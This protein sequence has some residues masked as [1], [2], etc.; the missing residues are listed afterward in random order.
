MYAVL[1]EKVV[2]SPA[3]KCWESL[4]F[5]LLFLAGSANAQVS[6]ASINGVIRDP[7]GACLAA[8]S[9][10]STNVDNPRSRVHQPPT[11]RVRMAL[12]TLPPGAIPSSPPLKYSARKVGGRCVAVGQAAT[13]DFALTVGTETTVVTVK[14]TAAQLDERRPGHRDRDR[15]GQRPPL[16]GRVHFPA[17][18]H[19]GRRC[20]I[21]RPKDPISLVAG[22]V[23][24]LRSV[25][26]IPF[27]SNGQ[28]TPTI[29]FSRMASQ[30]Y[31]YYS[32][33]AVAL[34]IDAVQE[35]KV[36]SHTD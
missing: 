26:P 21:D 4:V 16:N 3:C 17:R 5:Q 14:A 7:T 2:R 20:D 15:S 34:I 13:F 28:R 30:L 19:S 33:Y 32:T 18:A 9:I 6:T 29:T 8:L 24:P 11:T 36:V 1:S 22:S 10:A 27:L 12:L 23:P 31:C 35:F 25:R